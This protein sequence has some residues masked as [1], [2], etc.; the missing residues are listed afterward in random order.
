MQSRFVRLALT[1]AAFLGT[2]APRDGLAQGQQGSVTG[3]VTDAASGAPIGAAQVAIVGT[4]LGTQTNTEGQ[5]TIRGVTPG[6]VEVRVLRLGFGEQ[7][8]AVTVVAGQVATLNFQMAAVP[9]TLNPVVTTATGQQR[10]VE[11]GN[12][13]AQV[14]ASSIVETRAVSGMGDLLTSRAAGV[15]V[16]PGVQTGAGTRIRIR[17]TS[18]LSLTN[19]PIVVIDGIRVES[20]TGSS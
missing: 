13:I 8:Q 16:T 19:N 15:L 20:A 3:R 12:A 4:T 5:Y 14:D 10:R 17:G 2:L 7:R 11:V 6:Q 9:L 18:S 1:L